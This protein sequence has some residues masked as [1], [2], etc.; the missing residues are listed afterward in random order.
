MRHMADFLRETMERQD[1]SI[2]VLNF[3]GEKKMTHL[4][5]PE[6]F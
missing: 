1:N 2:T 5:L 6:T 4:K 3:R